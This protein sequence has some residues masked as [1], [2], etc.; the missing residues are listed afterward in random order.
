MKTPVIVDAIRTPIGALGGALASVRPDDLA[1]HVIRAILERNH[2]DPTLV[3]E[4]Y[5]G[6][7]NQAGEDNRNVA[8]MALLL[9]GMPVTVGGVTVN[10]LCASGLTAVNMAARAIRV[11]EGEIFIAG[12]V[13]SMSRAPYSLPKAE[14]GYP[15]GNLT[16]WDTALGWRY[17]NPK[18]KELYG[19]EQ[20]G[21]TAENIAEMKPHITREKQDEFALRSHQRAIAAIDSGKFAEEIVPVII[22]QRKGDP[23][24]V[25]TD[26]RPRRDTTL[27]SLAKLKPAFREGGTVTAGNSSGLNDGAAALLLMS[28]DKAQ[29]LGLQPMARLVASAAAG[30]HP[31]IMGLGPVPATQKA[32][33]RA[34]LS[35]DDIGLVELNEAFAVQALAVIEELGLEPERVNVNGG[36]IALGHPLGCSG[37]RI[38]TTLLHEMKRRGNVRYGLA[39]LCVGVGQGEATIVEWM[40]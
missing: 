7:A 36:A 26:E 17:P 14:S 21:E 34:G 40:G 38:L 39:T 37:A 35:L 24:V 33:A 12:G 1:A 25:D 6:C 22:P 16:A 15:F 31:R 2:L 20:M 9:A 13:E 4:V 8:R 10:R 28:E 32:L 19:I 5:F 29:E 30:V 11:G 23:K 27:E 3:E 18:M